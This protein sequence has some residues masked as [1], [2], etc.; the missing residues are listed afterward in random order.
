M[1]L[2][3]VN[4]FY[5]SPGTLLVQAKRS[6]QIRLK[7]F[8]RQPSLDRVGSKPV[9]NHQ[10]S[11]DMISKALS[12]G[13]PFAAGR[14]GTTE[15][16]IVWW[17][18]R[19]PERAMPAALLKN[20][21][22]LSGIFPV[23]QSAAIEFANSYL[24]A[25]GNLDLLGV[26]NQ[27]FFSG[28]HTMEREV[29]ERT[30]PNW[31]CSIE[32]LSPLGTSDSW[33]KALSGKKVLIIHPFSKTIQSQYQQNRRDIFLDK[34]WLPD[35]HLQVYKPFQTQGPE[36][37]EGKATTWIKS[38]EIMLD[39]VSRFSFDVALISAGAYGLPLAT[40]IKSSGRSALHIGGALQLFFGIRGGR[41]DRVSDQYPILSK[42]YSTAWVRPTKD[43]TPDWSKSVEGGAYW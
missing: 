41:W 9:L 26:R 1:L 20:G 10:E 30:R 3:K 39:E 34:D 31:L 16:D 24:E 28:Y 11:Q 35:F 8:R 4:G 33:V 43:E 29:I 42:Y 12:E 23:S 32:D 22:T 13:K 18:I 17:R 14:L 6:I 25:V 19:H 36:T 38:L 15:G 27:D 37:P 5:V 2:A 21:K 7:L 40:G